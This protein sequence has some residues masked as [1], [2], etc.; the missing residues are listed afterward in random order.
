MRMNDTHDANPSVP[1]MFP[2]FKKD[3]PELLFGALQN[4]PKYGQWSGVDYGRPEARERV[5]RTIEEV[6]ENYDVDGIELDFFRHPVL[7]R[8]HAWGESCGDPE[9]DMMTGLL[10]RVRRMTEQV[11]LRRGRPILVA[12]RTPDSAPYC[13]AI[14]LDV[15]R[16]MQEELLDLW[17]AGGYF[18]LCP[19]EDAVALGHKYGVQVYPS[20]DESRIRADTRGVRNKLECFRARAMQAWAAGVDGIYL[21]NLFNPKLPHWR[22]L[23]D[24][25]ELQK[26]DKLYVVAARGPNPARSYLAKGDR[27][28]TRPMLCPEQPTTLQAGQP[29][30]VT[31]LVGDDVLWGK[32]QGVAAEVTLSLEAEGLASA[33]A[34]GIAINGAALAGGAFADGWL[35]LRVPASS[36][37]RE[38]MRSKS[39]RCGRGERR[40]QGPASADPLPQEAVGH[41]LGARHDQPCCCPACRRGS[42]RL[43]SIRRCGWFPF[44]AKRPNSADRLRR[45]RSGTGLLRL[46][47]IR[48]ISTGWPGKACSIVCAV[49]DLFPI[50][51]AGAT[52]RESRKRISVRLSGDTRR[53]LP[54][55]WTLRITPPPQAGSSPRRARSRASFP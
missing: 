16:W 53:E 44:P 27:F 34:L 54:A 26:L 20:L 33:D 15:T 23:G 12:V 10:R 14:G 35:D 25:K 2:R 38:P 28:A 1:E 41:P 19:W 42:P 5:F 9:R 40:P 6:C 39:R 36:V 52:A 45:Q 49:F 43:A 17:V 13:E 46:P 55:R 50:R 31:L 29:C 3:H 51:A 48:R 32:D 22:E 37:R 21:F 7:F 11:G 18:R 47:C 4:R 24:P 8:R 30:S